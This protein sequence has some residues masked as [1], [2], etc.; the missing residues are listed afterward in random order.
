MADISTLHFPK[1]SHRKKVTLPRYSKELA[2]F[3]GIMM[4]D[5]GINNDWQAN[6]TLNSIT[7]SAY[8]KHVSTLCK[9]LFGITP[10]TR[11]RKGKNALVISL[12]SISVVD[13]LVLHG[14]PRGNKLKNGIHIPQWV[15]SKPAYMKAMIRGLIDTDG[16]L[17]VHVHRVRGKVYKNIGLTFTS[18]SNDL[19]F[20]VV[21]V[22][23]K[24]GIIPHI[25]KRGRDIYLYQAD[26]V[27]KYLK[28][29]GTSNKRIKS[30][31]KK[32][33]DARVV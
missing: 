15:F 32:W 5:G 30:V 13:F 6:V 12:A 3:F 9:K 24:F 19:L 29:F 27:E 2:E 21:E 11:K 25:T 33:R 1:N 28:I 8:V 20:Q 4:G 23:T 18:Y 16:C 10:A 17:F 7:D 31:Y 14:L 22:L 26:S